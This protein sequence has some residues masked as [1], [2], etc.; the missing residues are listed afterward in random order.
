MSLPTAYRPE[1]VAEQLGWSPRRVRAKARELGACRILG[2]KM[3]LLPEDVQTILEDTKCPSSSTA[4]AKSGTSVGQL[5]V[6]GYEA[7]RK[8]RTK[9]SRRERPPK[10]KPENGNVIS[11]VRNQS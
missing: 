6:G 2:N 8:L 5:P 9:P 3:I 7:L 1:D 10:L 11:M 4:A